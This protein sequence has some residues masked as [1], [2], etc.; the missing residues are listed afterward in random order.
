MR[1]S[2]IFT[3]GKIQPDLD[4]V[5]VDDERDARLFIIPSALLLMKNNQWAD[6]C[7]LIIKSF[8]QE[9]L[10]SL[11]VKD[12]SKAIDLL[13]PLLKEPNEVHLGL[14]PTNNG[15]TITIEDARVIINR[16]SR[17]RAIELGL[18]TELED[19]ALLIHGIADDKISDMTAVLLREKL[20]QYTQS[21]C[22]YYDIP[23][24][25]SIEKYEI[26]DPNG[27]QWKSSYFD[28]PVTGKS[29]MKDVILVPKRL[30]R[31]SL[32]YSYEG[33]YR[34]GI[35]EYFKNQEILDP[36][37]SLVRVIKST[38]EK[39]VYMKDLK[40]KYPGKKSDILDYIANNPELI[41]KY[42]TDVGISPVLTD[43]EI[44]EK[45]N[46]AENV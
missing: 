5:D 37:S 38:G 33:L 26:W 15:K 46:G 9:L 36:K 35:L 44:M 10:N 41:K 16:L 4:F 3:L 27:K 6:E 14:S 45:I 39:T 19:T 13:H 34:D 21:I 22:K 25:R 24:Q 7:V 23:I 17:S 1:I 40:K 20:V 11:I 31:L 18:V 30:V 43:K 28:I 29:N 2:E 32:N 42:K 12:K 8:F